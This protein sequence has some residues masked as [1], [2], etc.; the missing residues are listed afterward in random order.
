MGLTARIT[1]VERDDT[2]EN[3]VTFYLI[4]IDDN[5]HQWDVRKRYSDFV[6]L[7]KKLRLNQE[8]TTL[9]L[10]SK[11]FMGLRVCNFHE[12]RLVGLS[13]YLDHLTRQVHS[14][15]Q[16]STLSAFFEAQVHL[17]PKGT[18]VTES[19]ESALAEVLLP[20]TAPPQAARGGHRSCP[21]HRLPRVRTSKRSLDFLKSAEFT[22]FEASRP[23]LADSIRRCS[24]L[25]GSNGF[26]N[27]SESKF[28]ALRR[29]LRASVRPG[30][31][32]PLL[33]E[34]VP[35]KELVWEFVLLIRARR[36][37]YRHQADEVVAILE[38]SEAWMQVL[39][40]HE[41]LRELMEVPL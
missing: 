15:A 3:G 4:R 28:G 23:A 8:L 18:A 40:E 6:G 20:Q 31:G 5:S 16:S 22:S 39:N 30:S 24:E 2:V 33:L 25:L 1:G 9:K 38:S 10:P 27:D 41:D 26:E 36:P 35:G 19:R 7:D 29:N 21:P 34:D 13:S 14:L 17:Q 37:F 11:G 32:E 12:L